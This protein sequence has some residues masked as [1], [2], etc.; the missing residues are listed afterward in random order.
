MLRLGIISELGSGENKGFCRVSFD[1]VNM[2]SG[3]LPLPSMGTKTAKHW[4]PIEINSQV[5]CL[6]D[7]E[8]EQGVVAAVLWSD[9]NAP[10]DWA[11]ENTIGIEFA[12][13]AKLYYNFKDSKAFFDAPDTSLEATIKEADIEVSNN[14]SLKC[15]TLEIDGNVTVT[16]KIDANGNISSGGNIDANGNVKSLG[17]V[18]GMKVTETATQVTLGTHFHSSAMGPTSPP[19]PGT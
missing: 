6:M 4:I 18:E 16:G 15:K 9:S 5:A 10:P 8:C 7:E 2:V 1:E 12:D 13:G 19:T 17:T 14:V 11:D 3:W